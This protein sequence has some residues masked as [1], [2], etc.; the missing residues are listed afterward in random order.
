MN[1]NLKPPVQGVQNGFEI[2][3]D[4]KIYLKR[5]VTQEQGAQTFLNSLGKRLKILCFA[6]LT[7]LHST[8]DVRE[9]VEASGGIMC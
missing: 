9:T 2:L 7:T 6:R 4:N 5:V 1:D 3:S 8:Q